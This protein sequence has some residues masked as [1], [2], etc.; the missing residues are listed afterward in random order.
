[1]QDVGQLARLIQAMAAGDYL[2]V[3]RR[4]MKQSWRYLRRMVCEGPPTELDMDATVQDIGQRGLLL[5]PIFRARRVNRAEV[6]LLVDHDGSMV[7]FHGLSQ[8]LVETALQ[9]GRLTCASVYY[10]RNC[11]VRWLY[12]DPYYQTADSIEQVLQSLTSDYAGALIVSDG[13][14]A[15]GRRSPHRLTMT[16]QFL[17]QLSQRVRYIAWLNPMPYDRWADSTAGDIAQQIPMF[18]FD[19]AGLEAAID[20]LR[21]Q[22]GHHL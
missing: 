19:R 11:P 12:H 21:G 1:M 2:P 7:P 8:R 14:A 4:Q 22:R 16:Q 6:L 5:A 9:G 10:F 20:V 15:Y 17:E 18:E 13:G 3:T